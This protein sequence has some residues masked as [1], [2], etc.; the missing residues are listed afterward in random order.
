MRRG[1]RAIFSAVAAFA[2]I[3]ASSSAAFAHSEISPASTPA[4]AE[5]ELTLKLENERSNASTVKV[6]MFFPDGQEIVVTKVPDVGEWSGAPQGGPGG[7]PGALGDPAP[8]ITWQRAS[9][10]PS[11][12]LSLTFSL[13][14]PDRAGTIQMAVLQTY[15]D[16]SVDRWID[17]W[18]AGQPEPESPG[19]RLT[20]TAASV[21]TSTT[22]GS[23]ASAPT[24]TTEGSG[25]STPISSGGFIAGSIAVLFVIG[26]I[27][28]IVRAR[29][30]D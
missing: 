18:P 4:G 24:T 22:A 29:R 9:G 16:G 14:L 20:L 28:M 8:G 5:T 17:P 23:T 27:F 12:D 19:P 26:A 2:V 6:E 21:S 13:I 11:D 7:G 10:T 1:A 15:S 3:G 30:Q 25:S